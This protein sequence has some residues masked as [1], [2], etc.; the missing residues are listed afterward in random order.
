MIAISIERED[1]RSLVLF[2]GVEEGLGKALRRE[3]FDFHPAP[4][5]LGAELKIQ[6]DSCIRSVPTVRRADSPDGNWAL[7]GST[8]LSAGDI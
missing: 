1:V 7:L 2:N 3:R 4:A 8:S 5:F 6:R